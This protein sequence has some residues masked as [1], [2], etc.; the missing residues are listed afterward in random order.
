MALLVSDEAIEEKSLSAAGRVREALCE[1]AGARSHN[2]KLPPEE[3]GH[4]YDSS[5][6]S[7]MVWCLFPLKSIIAPSTCL[8]N[9]LGNYSLAC[10]RLLSYFT[11][12]LH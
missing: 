12:E 5:Y 4:I 3:I 7:N 8:S 9:K 10:L 6:L 2:S 1:H 11:S